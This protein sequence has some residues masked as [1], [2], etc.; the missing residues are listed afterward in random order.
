[1]SLAEGAKVLNLQETSLRYAG[2]RVVFACFLMALFLFGF[3]LYGQGVYFA[4]LQRRTAGRL[5]S[6]RARVR[7]LFWSA[8]FSRCSQANLWLG[9]A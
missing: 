3:G 2:W 5:F 6:S 4:E 7:C 9:S 8:I 1:M